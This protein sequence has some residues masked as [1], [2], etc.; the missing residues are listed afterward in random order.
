MAFSVSYEG[1]TRG[2]IRHIYSY[3]AT[4]IFTPTPRPFGKTTQFLPQPLSQRYPPRFYDYYPAF[5][6]GLPRAPAFD[7]LPPGEIQE[8]VDRMQK[9]ISCQR[10]RDKSQRSKGQARS[11][12]KDKVVR[13]HSPATDRQ[14]CDAAAEE[15]ENPPPMESDSSAA[16]KAAE[17]KVR[18]EEKDKNGVKDSSKVKVKSQKSPEA[19]G[20]MKSGKHK[21]RHDRNNNV[22]TLPP[23][24]S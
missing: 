13:F 4:S 21:K 9:P 5:N 17:V 2:N 24:S 7:R 15:V 6:I 16:D 23:V 22:C 3:K 8:M 12:R 1:L 18:S 20:D 11:R 10:E 14:D 19:S